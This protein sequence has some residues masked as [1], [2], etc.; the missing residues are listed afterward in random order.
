MISCMCCLKKSENAMGSCPQAYRITVLGLRD[1]ESVMF[2]LGLRKAA[3]FSESS[4][5][6][7]RTDVLIVGVD[8]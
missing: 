5:T 8:Q 3:R 7:R 2:T 4:R 6:Q 1:G